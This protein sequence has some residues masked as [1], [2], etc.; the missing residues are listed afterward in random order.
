MLASN[1][2]KRLLA[3]DPCLEVGHGCITPFEPIHKASFSQ[4]VFLLPFSLE[5]LSSPALHLSSLPFLLG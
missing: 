5:L 4:S 1:A 3:S 2:S